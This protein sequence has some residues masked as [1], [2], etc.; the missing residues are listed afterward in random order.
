MREMLSTTA[1]IYGQGMGEQV[2]LITDGRFSG[3]TRG[4][5]IGHVGPEAAVGGPIAL[6]KNGDRVVIDAERGTIDMLVDEAEIARR[7]A[8][9]KPRGTDY[10]S[11][12][13]WKY[14]Q[15]VGPAHLGAVTH[16]GGG[17]ETHSYADQ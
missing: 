10:N 2:A 3:A 13:L 5:C 7:R 1:A 17:A 15:L 14:A 16:P 8:E 11:G 6:L 12:A 9:W 4:F